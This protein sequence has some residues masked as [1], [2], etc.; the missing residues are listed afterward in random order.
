VDILDDNIFLHSTLVTVSFVHFPMR[1]P[2]FCSSLVSGLFTPTTVIFA[3]M[4]PFI[5]T[6]CTRVTHAAPTFHP[7]CSTC[8]ARVWFA[9]R[10]PTFHTRCTTCTQI[11]QKLFPRRGVVKKMRQR[12]V[13]SF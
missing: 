8:F 5:L 11:V 12:H 4:T 13:Y 9:D 3:A 7:V 10:T 6:R 2:V 1:T